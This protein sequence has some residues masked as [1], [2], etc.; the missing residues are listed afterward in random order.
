MEES[1]GMEQP[2]KYNGRQSHN[3]S[4]TG[5]SHTGTYKTSEQSESESYY[6]ESSYTHTSKPLTHK[7][8]Q[9]K[10]RTDHS[11]SRHSHLKARKSANPRASQKKEGE[12]ESEYEEVTDSEAS[13]IGS[14]SRQ[15][16]A[17]L[18]FLD[19]YGHIDMKI[20]PF[21][22]SIRTIDELRD[23]QKQV[24]QH[25]TRQKKGERSRSR[26]KS[27]SR[28][29]SPN[30]GRKQDLT[31][32]NEDSEEASK[33]F[34]DNNRDSQRYDHF[35]ELPLGIDPNETVKAKRFEFTLND[36]YFV[37]NIKIDQSCHRVESSSKL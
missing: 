18:D 36:Q 11:E 1:F 12:E 4:N 19:T 10:S 27:R 7:S 21:V 24:R 25:K 6:S 31:V 23:I 20:L 29:R 32:I 34:T 2:K 33:S 26:S 28:S 22:P 14:Y 5:K 13:S 37:Q 9:N 17:Y 30:N 8:Q 16:E 15:E 35:A 3:K